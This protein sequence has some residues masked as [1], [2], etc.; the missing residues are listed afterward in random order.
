MDFSADRVE[1]FNVL[2]DLRSFLLLNVTLHVLDKRRNVFEV[3][4]VLDIPEFL[5]DVSVRVLYAVH[6]FEEFVKFLQILLSSHRL[7]L[8]IIISRG[9]CFCAADIDSDSPR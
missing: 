9:V 3:N 6:S 8:F 1:L 7:F 4:A 5:A 2:D